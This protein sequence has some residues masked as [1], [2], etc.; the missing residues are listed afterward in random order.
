MTKIAV[1]SDVHANID[2][3][4]L[5]LKD[6]EQRG[7]DK[8]VCLGDLVTKYFYPDQVVDAIK[9]NCDIVVQGNCDNL[10]SSD[11]R[12]KFARSKLGI[13]NI[14]YLS[15]L[16]SREQL[17]VSGSL[18]TFFHA[19]PESVNAMFNP[20]FDNE[21]TKYAKYQIDDFHDMFIPKKII[22]ERFKKYADG[23]QLSIC[24]HTH[25]SYIGLVEDSDLKIILDNKKEQNESINLKGEN[26]IINTGSVGEA[27][28]LK[29]PD[30]YEPFLIDESLSYLIIE[31]DLDSKRVQ[32]LKVQIIKIPY[33]QTLKKVYFD[34]L[35]GQA[36][37]SFPNSPKDTEKVRKSLLAMDEVDIDKEASSIISS[38]GIKK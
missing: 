20:L 23:P 38:E 7:V 35:I 32:D 12:Y 6:I 26:A 30:S 24:G 16:P 18:L 22:E 29:Y 5:V 10:V 8:M 1:I 9:K 33:K 34:M 11:I 4:G 21:N 13:D 19:S 27:V 17:L 31:G 14:E 2:G 36:K 15:N 25:Q 28:T 37:G 3:L